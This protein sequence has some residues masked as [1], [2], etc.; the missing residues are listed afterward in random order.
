[1]GNTRYYTKDNG[2]FAAA[3]FTG[4]PYNTVLSIC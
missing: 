3:V 4:H 2:N 1:M